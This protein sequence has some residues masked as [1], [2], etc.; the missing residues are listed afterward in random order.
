MIHTLK[1]LCD[2]CEKLRHAHNR[3]DDLLVRIAKKNNSHD[4][5][6]LRDMC[7]MTKQLEG[8]MDQTI[9]QIKLQIIIPPAPE[10]KTERVLPSHV[11]LKPD[12]S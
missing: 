7:I 5:A 2:Q 10:H 1:S 3:I 12:E 4:Y 11:W 6:S 9:E 8:E